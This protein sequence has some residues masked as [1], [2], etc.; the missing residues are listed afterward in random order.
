MDG[1]IASELMPHCLDSRLWIWVEGKKK[2]KSLRRI[3][4]LYPYF[5]AAVVNANFAGFG[6]FLLDLRVCLD[7]GF[8]CLRLGRTLTPQY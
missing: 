7:A 2:M 1:W 8:Q 5:A 4:R 6:G 3:E